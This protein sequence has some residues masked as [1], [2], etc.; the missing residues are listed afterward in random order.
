MERSTEESRRGCELVELI[1]AVAAAGFLIGFGKAGVAGTLG[2][3]VT[4][5]MALTIPADQAIGLLLPMLIVADGFA[6]AA[7]WQHWDG[8][9]V[10]RLVIAALAGIAAGSLLVSAIS[11]AA[12]RNVIA[13]L[14]LLF[15]A[16]FAA[17]RWRVEPRRRGGVRWGAAAGAT[18]GLTST[19]AHLGGPPIIAYLMANRLEPRP[20]VATSVAFFA[21]IN[22]LKVPG[23]ALAGVFDAELIVASLW[24]WALIPVGVVLGRRMVDRIDR[25]RFELVTLVLLAAGAVLLLAG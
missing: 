13:V 8:A 1:P 17:M 20:M 3:F 16:G 24:A 21:A 19:L 6:L 7:H 5:L 25:N 22:L 2:P 4:V 10:V 11:A 12:L 23:Y 9:I 14:T 18:A 15:V